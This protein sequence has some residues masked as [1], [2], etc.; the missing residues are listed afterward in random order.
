MIER[1]RNVMQ[2]RLVQLSGLRALAKDNCTGRLVDAV[3]VSV[4]PPPLSMLP[5]N[6]A[7]ER[8]TGVSEI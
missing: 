4:K 1:V 7:A 6:S 8:P 2:D 3:T 5:I